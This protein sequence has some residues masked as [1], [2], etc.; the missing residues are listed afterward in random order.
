M[1]CLYVTIAQH[2]WLERYSMEGTVSGR[3]LYLNPCNNNKTKHPGEILFF[4]ALLKINE[5]SININN[6]N[7][8][9]NISRPE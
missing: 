6:E 5:Y 1:L 8:N 7:I 4:S 3:E 2:V 9:L